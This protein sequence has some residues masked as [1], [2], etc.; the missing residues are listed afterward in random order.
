VDVQEL[1]VDFYA[2]SGHKMLGPTGSGVLWARRELLDAMPPFLGGGEIIR[3]VHLRRSDWND[4]PWKFEAGTP[5]IAEEIGMAAAAEYLMA[6]G[7]DRAREHE[8]ELGAYAFD[9]L[10][11]ELPT[12]EL[13]GPLDPDLRGGVIPFN[14]PGV[15]AHDVAQVLDRFGVAVRAGHHCTMPL[16]ERLELAASAR[17]S[18]NVYSRP[19]DVDVL[20]E[21]LHEVYRLFGVPER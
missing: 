10:S 13:Y 6:L 2:F 19:A 4:V 18:F 14:V 3:E 9:L 5:A 17:A 8:R 7:M 11:R 16:H 1:G 21:G 12:L 20:V 15:H